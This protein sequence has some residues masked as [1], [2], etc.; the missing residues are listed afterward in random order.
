MARSALDMGLAAQAGMIRSGG[1]DPVELVSLSIERIR[2][3]DRRFRCFLS[4]FEERALSAAA[5]VSRDLKAGKAVGALAGV[6]VSVKDNIYVGGERCTAGSRILSDFVPTRDSD[7][8]GRLRRAGAIIVGTNNM[9]EF[10]TGVTTNNPW[11]GNVPNPWD[12]L[13]TA[14]GSSGGSAVAVALRAVPGSLGTDT[15]GSIRIPASFCGV[16]GVKP[17]YGLVSKKGVV[18]ASWR[19]DH[20]G[21]LTRSVEDAMLMLKTISGG[22][23][24]PAPPAG[25][26][27]CVPAD[28]DDFSVSDGVKKEFL[29]FLDSSGMAWEEEAFPPAELFRD[30]WICIRRSEAAA[31][32]RRWFRERPQDYSGEMRG[33]LEAGGK[34]TAVEYVEALINRRRIRGRL[35]ALL[36]RYDAIATPTTP[37]V[38]PRQ[39]GSE[40]LGELYRT[41]TSLTVV[42]NLTGFPAVSLPAG[43]S[44]GLPVGAQLAGRPYGEEVVM[45]LALAAER[46]LPPPPATL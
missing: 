23:A 45:K 32:H 36:G 17:T 8:V 18:P 41:L 26:R 13:R 20:V 29:R 21:P 9:S 7:V 11:H 24:R 4:V 3:A 1:I 25:G 10:A 33:F 2:K 39:G 44:E 6:P 35:G 37:V 42:H 38:A 30:T 40:G 5:E 15:G 46:E 34:V 28:L 16:V 14:G 43:L 19:L 22:A 31:F 27:V 12:E